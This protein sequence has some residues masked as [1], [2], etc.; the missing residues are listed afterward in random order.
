MKVAER[1]ILETFKAKLA[2]RLNVS[3]IILFGSR[4]RGDADEFSDMDVIVVLAG[5][6]DDHSRDVVSD[7]AWEAG[8]EAGIV[9]VPIV[10][11][12]SEWSS[13]RFSLL[14]KAVAQ[15]GLSI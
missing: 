9:V 1:R 5:A 12:R 15:E 14:G 2:N 6:A 13:A 11:S 10:F 4:A 7:C 3:E 8:L